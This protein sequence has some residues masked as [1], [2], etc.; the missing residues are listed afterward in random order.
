VVKTPPA[1]PEERA[2]VSCI[3][4]T[5]GRPAFVRHAIRLFEAQDYP[6]RELVVVDDEPGSPELAA[7]AAAGRIRLLLAP[8]GESIGAKRNRACA[9]A[10]GAYIAH[11][12][13]DDWYGAARLDAQIRPLAGGRADVTGLTTAVFADLETGRFWRVSEELHRQ[14]FLGNVA[15][16]TL[17]YRRALWARSRGYPDCSL[18]EDA[19]FLQAICRSGARLLELPGAG[20][21]AYV[22][23]AGNSWRFDCGRHG[24]PRGW[25]RADAPPFSI[26]DRAFYAAARCRQPSGMP[27]VTCLMPTTD[28]LAF[29]PRAIAYFQRQDY[30]RLELLIVDDGGEPV[31]DVVPDDP[32]IR[33][34]RLERRLRLGD[35]RNLGC[36]L[37][38]G[39]VIVHW[40]DDDWQAPHRVSYQV[41]RLQ[42]WGADVCGPGRLLWFDPAARRAWLYEYPGRKTERWIAGNGLCYRRETWERTPFESREVGEDGAF[43][44]ASGPPLV[45]R[46][47]RFMVGV[48]HDRNTCRKR[49][50]D[51]CWRR[52]ELREVERLL[53]GDFRRYYP[54]DDPSGGIE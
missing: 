45:L 34:V 22:R 42:R 37:A 39:S 15:G 7:L 24:D 35:K 19:R 13:D 2:L 23:H 54:T 26:D 53:A 51:S 27:L 4:P 44:R 36:S 47:H 25:A 31:A 1:A 16:G 11:W 48:V 33:Y 43:T 10:R 3:M 40:D 8:P 12:D 5:C 32:R 17:V 14:M 21:Y 20:H 28:R 38:R 46:D 30:A 41:G 49:T 52:R 18:A 9:A 29:V 50:R 6:A